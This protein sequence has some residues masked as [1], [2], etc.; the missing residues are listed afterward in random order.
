MEAERTT[1]R[2]ITSNKTDA[3]PDA[4]ILDWTGSCTYEWTTLY[5]WIWKW[6]L[7]IDYWWTSAYKFDVRQFSSSNSERPKH[8]FF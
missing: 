5:N 4:T 2:C 7:Y 1:G 6:C 8:L 3:A